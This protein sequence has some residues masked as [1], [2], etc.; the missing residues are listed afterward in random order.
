MTSAEDEAAVLDE[1][2]LLIVEAVRERDVI[3]ADHIA[4]FIA[5]GYPLST[6]SVG[7]ISARIIE[8]AFAAGV[9]VD[10]RSSGKDESAVRLSL[11]DTSLQTPN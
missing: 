7:E 2:R 10:I 5:A 3:R 1:V 4:K 6:L 8:A 9:E 11:P